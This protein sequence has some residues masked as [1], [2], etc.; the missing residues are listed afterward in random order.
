MIEFL[1]VCVVA[2]AMMGCMALLGILA[3]KGVER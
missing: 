3:A 1:L 2:L